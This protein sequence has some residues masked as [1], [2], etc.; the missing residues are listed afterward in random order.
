MVRGPMRAA[1]LLLCAAFAFARTAEADALSAHASA[2]TE[3]MGGAGVAAS[4]GAASLHY[5]P[6]LVAY[7]ETLGAELSLQAQYDAAAVTPALAFAASIPLG[8]SWAVGVALSPGWSLE[9][10]SA[11]SGQEAP[12][13]TPWRTYEAAVC[14]MWAPDPQL[15][16]S[17][18]SGLVRGGLLLRSASEISEAAGY[19]ASVRVG[20]AWRSLNADWTLGAA[21]Q[22]TSAVLLQGEVRGETVA[23]LT[24]RA[25][26]LQQ[27]QAGAAW[28]ASKKVTWTG[29]L[30]LW[31]AGALSGFT[32]SDVP[33]LGEV[34]NVLRPRLGVELSP[35]E[36][37][38]VRA[39]GAVDLGLR[40]VERSAAGPA[41]PR[42]SAHAGVGYTSG[43]F[44]F[45][46]GASAA[47]PDAAP[48]RL[49]ATAAAA[50]RI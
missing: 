30:E 20:V 26:V 36:Y 22:L 27:G 34:P 35:T 8:R 38:R 1:P 25:P 28:R 45:D 10:R 9:P 32:V 19:G 46:F 4:H 21:W 3:G 24:A 42:F 40:A 41:L 12:P 49:T 47:F 7:E 44:E 2:R 50:F 5:N 37:L 31:G 14:A 29:Q 39:G 18:S 48:V 23:P 11:L 13:S 33:V 43:F 16:I 6:A 15:G 17:L